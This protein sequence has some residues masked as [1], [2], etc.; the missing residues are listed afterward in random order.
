MRVRI[1]L[2]LALFSTT[3]LASC[4]PPAKAPADSARVVQ[5]Y[6]IEDFY[7]NT[8]YIGASFSSDGRRLLVNSNQTG[9][10]N[11]WALPIDGGPPPR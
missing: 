9:V 3:L 1:C 11:V 7:Q 10:F 4:T 8:A 6:S 2:V 5:Q